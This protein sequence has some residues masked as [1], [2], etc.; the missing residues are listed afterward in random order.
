MKEEINSPIRPPKLW[1]VSE[2]AAFLNI[3]AGTVFHWVSRKKIPCIRFGSR[4]L[5]FDPEAVRR[6]AASHL[7]PALTSNAESR[8]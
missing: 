1:K 5:R 7:E 2:V 3:S 8:K 4:C 6:W